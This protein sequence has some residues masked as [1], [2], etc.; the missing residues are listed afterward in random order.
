MEIR[1]TK[2]NAVCVFDAL[3]SEI[4]QAA[5]HDFILPDYCPDIFRVLKCAVLPDITSSGINGGR[6]TFDLAVT[7]RVIYRSESGG[8]C[9]VEHSENFTRSAELSGDAVSPFVRITP[10]VQSVGCRVVDKRRLEVR[11]SINC[12]MR[13][14]A[15]RSCELVSAAAGCG[16]QLR[17]QPTLYPAKRLTAAKRITV[18]E[19]LELAEGKPS[20][21]TILRCGVGIS[22]G[23]ESGAA[24]IGCVQ[25]K[26]VQGKLVTKGE[27][28]VQLLYLPKSTGGVQNPETMR[29][30]IPFSQI[31]DIAGL[32][33]D[34]DVTAEV[35]PSGC[36]ITPKSENGLLE[37]EL[38][39][40]VNIRA[41]K[42]KTAELVTDAYSTRCE[43]NCEY[44]QGLAGAPGRKMR[45]GTAAKA[46]LGSPDGSV[47]QVYDVW[48]ENVSVFSR[49]A[50]SEEVG[51]L[52]YGKLTFCMLGRLAD[53]TVCYSEREATFEQTVE[54]TASELNGA[55]TAAAV[56]GCSYTLGDDGSVQAKA[57]LAVTVT[58]AAAG[59]GRLIT[60]ITPDPER[61]KPGNGRC[62]VRICY[63]ESGESLWD[64]AKKYSTEAAA[65][66]EENPE[67]SRVLIIPMKN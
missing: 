42:Y 40:T 57:E 59:S 41:V 63:S 16:I 30:V 8:I 45:V 4:M 51:G 39:L 36:T 26:L 31:I 17:R 29:F 32:D 9:C 2:E 58:S 25:T 61:P 48:S 67:G 27:A 35:E 44:A 14:E 34:F 52:V 64:I 66:A 18:I 53:G 49:F 37:C 50:E 15:E 24:G 65:I 7:I 56:T 13:V 21:G 46:V 5:E 6:P 23:A 60:A 54:L 12:R 38:I 20:F 43:I 28:A 1:L 11:G 3:D 47:A 10:V 55:Q 62:A 33:E 22:G 19:E